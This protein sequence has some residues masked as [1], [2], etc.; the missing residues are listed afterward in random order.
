ML[1]LLN[2]RLHEGWMALQHQPSW[3][4]NLAMLG[5]CL[6]GCALLYLLASVLWLFV[7]SLV[8][9][10]KTTRAQVSDEGSAY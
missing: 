4:A 3:L 10:Y 6:L 2:M 7:L 1:Y 5:V 8:G 9:V